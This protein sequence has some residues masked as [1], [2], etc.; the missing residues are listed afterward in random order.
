EAFW[1]LFADADTFGALLQPDQELIGPL[2]EHLDANPP[3]D[4]IGEELHERARLVLTQTEY[5]SQRYHVVV[6]N[7]PYMGS[8]NMGATLQSFAKRQ[9]KKSRRDLLAMFIERAGMLALTNAIA[10]FVT[11]E[12]WMFQ[13]GFE[14]FRVEVMRRR[15]LLSLIHMPYQGRGRTSMGINFG[16][17]AFVQ[18][19]GV[20][21]G[22][23]T[24]CFSLRYWEIDE[25]GEPYSFPP[26]NELAATIRMRDLDIIPG[27]PVAFWAT[28]EQLTAFDSLPLLEDVATLKHGMSTSDN[29][30]FLRQW[31]E[32]SRHR[33]EP[34]AS[35]RVSA[36]AS[37]ARWFPFCKGGSERRWYGNL[38]YVVNWEDDGREIKEE[39]N[40][41]YPYLNGNLGFV[42]GAED[43]YFRPAVT[44]STATSGSASFRFLPTG[45][46]VSNA[47]QT[48]YPT[49]GLSEQFLLGVLNDRWSS[50]YLSLLSP[51][52]GYELGYVSKIPVPD[53]DALIESAAQELVAIARLDW[54]ESELAW[55][56]NRSP[57]LAAG[58]RMEDAVH[59]FIATCA[60]R[61]SATEHFESV[62]ARALGESKSNESKGTTL[63]YEGRLDERGRILRDF[64][65]Y[66]A[67]ALF[68]R[69]SLDLE[70]LVLADQGDSLDT[71]LS[72]LP[73]PSFVPDRDNVIPVVDGDWF[74]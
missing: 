6:A 74:E 51:S 11:M 67:G 52:I 61:R 9:F 30:R 13:G 56:F 23:R 8:G 41:K 3:T 7:P 44:W 50:E 73:E 37:G 24:A 38:D 4:L 62:I 17:V 63:T 49:T 35:D 31:Y 66:S 19:L 42:I 64:L 25:T 28:R 46:V 45:S 43:F 40:R 47:G 34:Q 33:F 65:S 10:A 39:S 68:G 21:R 1:N 29:N 58:S 54:D 32:V 22:A 18:S 36:V 5:L 70:G 72:R 15:R 60:E 59:A 27:E 48:L 16:T 14:D 20:D 71:F 69:F 2:R 26:E 12:S 57:L 55:D 53:F